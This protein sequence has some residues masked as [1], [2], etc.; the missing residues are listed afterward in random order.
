MNRIKELRKEHKITQE[1]LAAILGISRSAIAMYET[2][3]CDL[4][5]DILIACAS[6][7]DVSTDYLLG[8]SDIK[9]AP[10]YEDAGLSAEEAELLKLF[11]SAPEA[12]QDAALRVLEANQRKE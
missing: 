5:N 2:E 6:F 3:K 9:K 4:S 7:F 12:L 11:R 10:S 8:Q 1:K